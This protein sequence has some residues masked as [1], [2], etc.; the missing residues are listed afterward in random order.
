MFDVVVVYHG[1]A[2]MV[3]MVTLIVVRQQVLVGVDEVLGV[4]RAQQA[5]VKPAV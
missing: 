4:V 2:G 5:G 1:S 3:A